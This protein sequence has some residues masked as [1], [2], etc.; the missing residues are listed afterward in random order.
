MRIV[1]AGYRSWALKIYD[2]IAQNTDNTVLIIRSKKQYD[3]AAIK[4]FKPDLI[5][6]YGWSWT[7]SDTMTN[8]YK[9][10]M[11]HP[12]PLP[13][14]RGGS[15]IQNQI[16]NNEKKSAVTLF[17]I[18]SG[19]D[20][21]DIICQKEFSLDGHMAE[22]FNRITEIGIE[23]TQKL[24]TNEYTL[25]KQNEEGLKICK[26]RV[27]KDSEITIEELQTQPSKYLFNKIRMLEDPYPN[28]FIKTIDNKKILI[29]MAEIG[30]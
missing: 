12:S 11:L 4:D 15:P 18:D 27:P 17:V 22:I 16:I 10:I 6:Y 24:L 8:H 5:L 21:G 30:D 14:Y 2:A 25:T 23:L 13:R 19:V 28:A 9:C 20:T 29:K 7:V 26:R 3:E 1:C